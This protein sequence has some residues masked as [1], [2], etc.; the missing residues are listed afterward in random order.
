MMNKKLKT[1]GHC[2]HDSG[3][4]AVLVWQDMKQVTMISVAT[5]IKCEWL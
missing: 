5:E 2:G 4:V 3:D 1:G